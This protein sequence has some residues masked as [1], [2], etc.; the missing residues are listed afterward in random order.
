VTASAVDRESLLD[1]VRARTWYHTLELAPGLVT[2]GMFDLRPVVER[3]GLP[4]RLDG[5]RA[6]DVGTYDG[7]WA[8]ELER[9]G[10]EVVALDVD[11]AL[12]VD[13]P[14]RRRPDTGFSLGDGFAL[15]KEMTGL[16]AERLVCNV[17]AASPEEIG[18]FDLV[19]CGSVLIHM[20]DQ[21]LALER[22]AALCRGQFICAEAYDPLMT[23]LPF[24]AA[25]YRA[26]RD[27]ST[28]FWAPGA[29]TWRR[30]LWT[31]GFEQ[32]REH[33]RFKLRSRHG[34][35][36]RHVVLHARGTA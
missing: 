27:A 4:E 11:D 16:R 33:A 20:R 34:F 15:V 30:M 10:A 23:L 22:L 24:P 31:A 18:Y 14:P 8:L 19:F 6:L 32:P 13:W 7:F 28:V 3:Y 5:L 12:D 35:S 2:E 1:R 26:D 9:R 17:Y 21:L 25:R 36:V 29:R